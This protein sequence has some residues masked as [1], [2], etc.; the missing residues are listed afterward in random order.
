[1]ALGDKL[2]PIRDSCS[3]S[4]GPAEFNVNYSLLQATS[5]PPPPP[6]QDF[7]CAIFARPYP[8]LSRLLPPLLRV[9]TTSTRLCFY[10]T[11]RRCVSLIYYGERSRLLSLSREMEIGGGDSIQLEDDFNTRIGVEGG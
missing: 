2:N 7:R 11:L 5:L 4:R 6:S 8:C 3:S 9:Y 1:M 10:S